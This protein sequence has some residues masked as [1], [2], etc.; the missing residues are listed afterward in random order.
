MN[1]LVWTL[2]NNH[3]YDCIWS[4]VTLQFGWKFLSNAL[5]RWNSNFF[6]KLYIDYLLTDFM[7]D[8]RTL[9][10]H[11]KSYLIIFFSQSEKIILWRTMSFSL[12]RS[13]T[14]LNRACLDQSILNA[15]IKLRWRQKIG[16]SY[17]I[18]NYLITRKWKRSYNEQEWEGEK[19]CIL[20]ARRWKHFS[21]KIF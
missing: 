17:A 21:E 10:L 16:V 14:L 19:C 11:Q 7:F 12:F 6:S 20:S 15:S 9:V 13:Y 1:Y 8:F 2:N 4:M 18:P 5:L 3:N